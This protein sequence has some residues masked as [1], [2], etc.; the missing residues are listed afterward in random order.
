ME[1]GLAKRRDCFGVNSKELNDACRNVGLKF[2]TMANKMVECGKFETAYE[3][4]RRGVKV[5]KNDFLLLQNMYKIMG[6]ME[7]KRK[8]YKLALHHLIYALELESNISDMDHLRG[9]QIHLNICA[10]ASHLGKHKLAFYHAERAIKIL[11]DYEDEFNIVNEELCQQEMS[12]V[13]SDEVE[14]L[15]IAYYNAGVEQEHLNEFNFCHKYY[16]KGLALA[17]KCFDSNHVLVKTLEQS[18]NAVSKEK[19][20][21]CSDNIENE[22]FT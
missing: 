19:E 8:N 2:I 9:P 10:L 17:T 11:E 20:T 12:K 15:A 14:T 22:I 21:L 6:S 13:A 16:T 4:L 5:T 18:I 7:Q 3:Y 1:L